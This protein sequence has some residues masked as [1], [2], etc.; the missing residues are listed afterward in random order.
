MNPGNW[1]AGWN[2]VR[3]RRTGRFDDGWTV[4]IKV[5]FETLRYRVEP[6]HIWGIQ[7]RRVILR[8]TTRVRIRTYT[9]RGARRLMPPESP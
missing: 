5:A 8:R 6:P 9:I 1:N 7:L 3:E 4:K 2:P